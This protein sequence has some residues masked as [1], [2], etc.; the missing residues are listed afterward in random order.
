[1]FKKKVEYQAN[2]VVVVI[3]EESCFLKVFSHSYY[4]NPNIIPEFRYLEIG[5]SKEDNLDYSL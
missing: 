4:D 5:N 1:M 2:K 3:Y